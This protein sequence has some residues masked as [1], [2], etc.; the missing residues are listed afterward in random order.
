[1]GWAE[2]RTVLLCII[3]YALFLVA[4]FIAMIAVAIPVGGFAAMSGSLDSGGATAMVAVLPLAELVI[5]VGL[6]WPFGRLAMAL[7]M[8]VAEN[9][10]RLF[11]AW[12]LTRGYGW[13]IVGLF[14]LIMLIILGVDIL[15]Y[16]GVI[17]VVASVTSGF[18]PDGLRALAQHPQALA[19]YLA[20]AA[21]VYFL[22][23]AVV[24]PISVAPWARAY[25]II[26]GRLSTDAVE[27][28]E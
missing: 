4:F 16:G 23:V 26:A 25:Q 6:A 13:K 11:E 1:V 15:L 12:T 2:L 5:M 27:V 21:V 18:S 9:R 17:G 7:P 28:F 8:S 19:P 14:L 3:L 24:M 10:F 22:F 20:G